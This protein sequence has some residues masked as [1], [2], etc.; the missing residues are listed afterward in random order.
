MTPEKY[1][2][3]IA[4]SLVLVSVALAIWVNVWWLIVTTV[5]GAG[6]VISGFTDKCPCEGLLKKFGVG[7]GTCT[8]PKKEETENKDQC[9]SGH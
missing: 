4:G 7:G 2:K 3:I 1:A 5:V 9:C 8:L 6:L